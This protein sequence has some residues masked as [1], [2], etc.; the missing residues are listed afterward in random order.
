MVLKQSDDPKFLLYGELPSSEQPGK[1]RIVAPAF[2]GY[3][4]LLQSLP[5]NPDAAVFGGMPTFNLH[6]GM[7]TSGMPWASLGIILTREQ[8]GVLL[9]QGNGAFMEIEQVHHQSNKWD[10]LLYVICC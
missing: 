10:L 9:E 7:M 1:G 4:G 6:P 5:A 2:S 8:A 3:H